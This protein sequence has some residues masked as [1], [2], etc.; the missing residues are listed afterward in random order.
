MIKYVLN[1]YDGLG[2]DGICLEHGK[3]EF[4]VQ[5]ALKRSST[6]QGEY[7]YRLE[8]WEV[9]TGS[10]YKQLYGQTRFF[11]DGKEITSDIANALLSVVMD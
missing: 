6:D 7:T 2:D 1:Y 9:V 3:E 10:V 5:E 4:V 11:Q 8:K